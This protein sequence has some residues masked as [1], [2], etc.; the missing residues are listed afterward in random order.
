MNS[1]LDPIAGVLRGPA[2]PAVTTA[3]FD[4]DFRGALVPDGLAD[5]ARSTAHAQG[6][7]AGWAEGKRQAADVAQAMAG[8]A[9]TTAGQAAEARSAQLE[10]AVTAI[11]AA[12]GAL[13]H[14][15][16]QPSAE[17]AELILRAALAL[18]E[19]LVGHELAATR[20]PGEDAIRRALTLAPLGRP[21]QVRLSPADH[22]VVAAAGVRQ[23][24]DGRRVTLL[25]DP[26]LQPGDA[27]AECDATTI[28]ASLGA[29]LH[30][31]R[32]VLGD[33]RPATPAAGP[34]PAPPVRPPPGWALS[35]VE[36]PA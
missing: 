12:A 10:Q 33:P 11:A 24:I 6:Y 18:T 23:D 7:A 31:V 30:R 29:A 36:G 16:V 27:V 19:T 34:P 32:E 20:T 14:R 2:G 1:Y 4:L 5:E 26:A 21:V 22:A 28:D 25:S 9:R 13:E 8:R 35:T 17:A 15:A 3:R